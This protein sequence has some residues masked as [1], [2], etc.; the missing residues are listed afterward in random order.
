MQR[1][2]LLTVGQVR[3]PQHRQLQTRVCKA[4]IAV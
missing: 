3:R 1:S 4:A 2:D